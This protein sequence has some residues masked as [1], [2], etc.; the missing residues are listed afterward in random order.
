M[1]DLVERADLLIEGNRPGVT[2]RLGVGPEPCLA[3]NPRLV[4]GRMTGWGQDGPLAE[5]A[6]H[7]IAYIALTGTLGM[8]GSPGSPRPPPPTSSAT[9]RAARS[10][11]SSASS[12]PCTTRA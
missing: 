3:R 6:G 11:S 9:T 1:L 5:R 4:Y 2:E 12:P 7:D 10:T 8:I